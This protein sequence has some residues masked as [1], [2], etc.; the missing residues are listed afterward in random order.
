MIILNNLADYFHNIIVFAIFVNFVLLIVL[1]VINKSYLKEVFL[2]INITT[3]TGLTV[4]FLI[5]FFLRMYLP[6]H[7]HILYIDEHWYME[8]GKNIFLHGNQDYY[9]K[10]IGWPFILSIA[11]GIFGISNWVAINTSIFFGALSVFVVFFAVFLITEDKIAAFF[12]SALFA[13]LPVHIRWSAT[14]E[15][16]VTSLFFILLAI[17][18]SFLYLKNKKES[19]LWLSFSSIAFASQI[20]SE[21]Y[22]LFPLFIISLLIYGKDT[23]KR[24]NF[25]LL[26][27]L[28]LFAAISLPN[29]IQSL[30]FQIAT[31]WISSDTQ[32]AQ[33]G[34]NWSLT[35]LLNNSSTYGVDLF[36]NKYYSS[37]LLLFIV[38]GFIYLFYKKR[39][40]WLFLT[41]WF[42]LIW[43]IY[44]ASWFQTLGGRERFYLSFY[45]VI[46]TLIVYGIFFIS[47]F[48]SFGKKWINLGVRTL[49]FLVVILLFIPHIKTYAKMYSDDAHVLEANL[50]ELAEKN[51]SNN[52]AIVANLPTILRSTTNLSVVDSNSFLQDEE[53]KKNVLKNSCALFIEDYTCSGWNRQSYENCREIKN[54]FSLIEYQFYN[55]NGAR[56][57]FYRIS[58]K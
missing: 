12:S 43:L 34:S 17:F 1:L 2:K 27:P 49:L 5:A 14:A 23:F 46:I 38:P 10:S 58:E 41:I 42:I 4:I 8:A 57:T 53:I 22:F 56:Y 54:R 6:V 52:C 32:G 44:F 13:L 19:L 31:N 3:W 48:L 33:I 11:F 20:R 15:T 51:I 30:N 18:F 35:N 26:L 47:Q 37:A 55:N 16:N 25:N 7:S 50:P 40:A 36:N 45:P 24:L 39:R 21:N 28:L 9:P 29:F